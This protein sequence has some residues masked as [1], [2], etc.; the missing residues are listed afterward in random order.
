[1][2]FE[3]NLDPFCSGFVMTRLSCY[4]LLCNILLFRCVINDSLMIMMIVRSPPGTVMMV[5]LPRSDIGPYMWIVGRLEVLNGR[6][7]LLSRS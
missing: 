3:I 6:L 7:L 5:T 2:L 1:M 4:V